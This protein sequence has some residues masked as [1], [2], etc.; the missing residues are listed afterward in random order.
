M[1]PRCLCLDTRCQHPTNPNGSTHS[2]PDWGRVRLINTESTVGRISLYKMHVRGIPFDQERIRFEACAR[3]RVRRVTWRKYHL[4]KPNLQSHC[5]PLLASQASHPLLPNFLAREL[6]YVIN[7]PAPSS[8]KRTECPCVEI[9]RIYAFLIS[10][11][12]CSLNCGSGNICDNKS[13][14]NLHNF[15]QIP[16]IRITRI[17]KER[18]TSDSSCLVFKLG[19]VSLNRASASCL[20]CHGVSKLEQK[21]K[22]I[23]SKCSS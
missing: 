1:R 13:V 14:T 23:S 21:R 2:H 15:I 3:N 7:S 20:V 6:D 17:R 12:T 10:L 8:L 22:T 5:L 16:Y 19:I 9:T 18:P 4:S 11:T